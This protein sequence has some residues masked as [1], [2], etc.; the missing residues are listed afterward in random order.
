MP[1]SS[2]NKGDRAERE[3]VVELRTKA[4]D[5][6]LDNAQRKLGAGRKED[7]GDLHVFPDVAVQVKSMA[8]LGTALREAATGADVQAANG[9]VSFALGMVPVPRARQGSVRWLAACTQWPDSGIASDE[10]ARFATPETLVAHL[11][12]ENSG[13]PRDRRIALLLRKGSDP[14]VVATIE[15]W[16]NAYRGERKAE[17]SAPAQALRIAG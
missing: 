7:T 10:V 13:I 15:A 1:N 2:K 9:R 3:A 5:L 16:L 8:R 11:R 17:T 14:L 6:V 12:N 4:P